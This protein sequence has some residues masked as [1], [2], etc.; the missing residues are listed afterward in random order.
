MKG[1]VSVLL[2]SKYSEE[3][4]RFFELI[5]AAI[6]FKK[7]CV[8]NE[9]TRRLIMINSNKYKIESVP[10][11]FIFFSDGLV[12]KYEGEDA[13]SWAQ[14]TLNAMRRITENT[15]RE[16]NQASA[17]EQ[18]T[19]LYTPPQ[20]EQLHPSQEAPPSPPPEKQENYR[21]TLDTEPLITKDVS[22][23]STDNA[24]NDSQ[25]SEKVRGIKQ[26]SQDNILNIAQKL[27]KQREELDGVTRTS[28]N[29]SIE[30]QKNN[31]HQQQQ[32]QPQQQHQPQQQQ[33]PTE[34]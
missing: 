10:A 1:S 26:T 33:Q 6:D 11:V 34:A 21:R 18:K 19:F 3:C 16:I 25:D 28:N 4:T 17:A 15:V 12:K 31:V 27:Q 32:Q 24:R 23:A 7:L 14:D 13:F 30:K 29:E 9:M 8:D 22:E 5:G 20:N 2:Y